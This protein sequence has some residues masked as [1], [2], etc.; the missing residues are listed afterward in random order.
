MEGASAAEVVER[1]AWFYVLSGPANTF[2]KSALVALDE[3]TEEP[4][5]RLGIRASLLTLLGL[6]G[7]AEEGWRSV[8]LA[9]PDRG[10]APRTARGLSRRRLDGPRVLAM[11]PLPFGLVRPPPLTDLPEVSPR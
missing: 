1:L 6:L 10:V 7:E 11:P 2:L 4:A 9:R 8:A 5:V 3:L